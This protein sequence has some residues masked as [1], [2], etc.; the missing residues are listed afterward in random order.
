MGRDKAL[1]EIA[2]EPLWQLQ[3]GTLRRLLPDQLMISGPAREEWADYEIVV[4]EIANAGPLAGVAAALRRCTTARLVV[5]AVDLPKM[6]TD[7]LR[8]LLDHC[9]AG[10]GIVPR[11]S[12]RFEPL[13]AVYSAACL[14]LAEAAL[15]EGNFSMQH[16]VRQALEQDLLLERSITAEEAVLFTNLNTPADL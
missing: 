9:R 15:R 12:D 11:H 4:D 1:L 14:A 10:Q 6:T 16:F 2:G 5:L 3:L 8:S 7:Y 13:A